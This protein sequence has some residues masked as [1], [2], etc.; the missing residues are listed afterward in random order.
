M[1][2][3]LLAMVFVLLGLGQ[4]ALADSAVRIQ[5]PA[6]FCDEVFADVSH[7]DATE[8]AKKIAAA[9]GK[10]ESSETL[11]NALKVLDGKKIDFIKKVIDNNIGGA[12]R[13]IV[14]Y[15]YVENLGFIYFRFNYKMSSTGW[16]L[17]NFTF[18]SE[19][20]ELFPHDFVDR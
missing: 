8:I 4:S 11:Q 10:P 6:K 19:T 12:L 20:N 18:K 7:M 14:F 2:R 5:D 15:S 9:I 17:A 13:Q 3:L 16:I 1:A